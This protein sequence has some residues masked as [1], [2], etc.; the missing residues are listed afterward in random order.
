[1][2][3]A[4]VGRPHFQAVL[5]NKN[6]GAGRKVHRNQ[7]TASVEQANPEAAC[8]RRRDDKPPFV[9]N[10]HLGLAW[11]I[12]SPR[13]CRLTASLP[14][15]R[16]P[17]A[18]AA[19]AAPI[20]PRWPRPSG[21]DALAETPCSGEVWQLQPP[22]LQGA[23][24]RPRGPAP[25]LGGHHSAPVT[26]RVTRRKQNARPP[27]PGLRALLPRAPCR[28]QASPGPAYRGGA[29]LDRLLR[30]LHLEEVAVGREDGDGTVVAHPGGR[31]SSGRRRRSK[32]HTHRLRPARPGHAAGVRGVRRQGG[33]A[34]RR[35]GVGRGG[36]YHRSPA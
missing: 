35:G 22:V 11:E 27:R 15:P 34:A 6:W 23:R 12:P 29:L 8:H 13:G 21:G 30:V 5:R 7:N 9:H 10:A 26:S 31:A 4:G 25:F 16:A 24:R 17:E 32:A 36:R 20:A 14:R 33:R 1:M 28:A 2:M 19:R 3:L 18:S